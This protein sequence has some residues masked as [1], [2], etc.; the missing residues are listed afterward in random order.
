MEET[1]AA[2]QSDWVTKLDG[3]THMVRLFASKNALS[4][5]ASWSWLNRDMIRMLSD[6][7]KNGG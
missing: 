6:F 3:R 7:R 1:S 5:E 2:S 4:P